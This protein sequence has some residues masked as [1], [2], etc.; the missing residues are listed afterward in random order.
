MDKKIFDKQ[1]FT[2]YYLPMTGK[3]EQKDLIRN[4]NWFYGWFD[5]LQDWYD[6]RHG[7]GKRALEIGCS[8]GAAAALLA[9]RGFQVTATDLSSYAVKNAQ[10]IVKGVKFLKLDV[11][12]KPPKKLGKFDLIYAFEVIEHLPQHELALK[13]LHSLLKKDGALICS[14]PYPYSYVFR[15]VTHVNVRHPLDW[16][17]IFKKTGFSEV[18]YKQVG[19]IPFFYRFSAHYHIK[20]PFG[21]PTRYINSPIFFYAKK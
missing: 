9:E 6:F 16:L 14:T 17:R 8:I 19:F 2:E 21:L 13:N 18:K 12:K 10:K 20:L 1:Y 5:A 7:K 4:K 15:D 11:E 3:F